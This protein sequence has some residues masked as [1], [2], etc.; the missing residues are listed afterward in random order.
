MGSPSVSE[1]PRG[2]LGR[3]EA[4]P[5]PSSRAW[6]RGLPPSLRL[7]AASPTEL[8]FAGWWPARAPLVLSPVWLALASLTW[9]AP[10]PS[11]GGRVLVSLLCL[12]V[13][14]GLI[15]RGRP[16]RV[17]VR[18]QPNEL[19]LTWAGGTVEAL[20]AA[21]RWLLVVEQAPEAPQPRYAAVLV[22]GE[23]RWPL[24]V[25]EDPARLLR[26]L[27]TVLSHWPGEVAQ[28]WGLPSSVQPWV[29]RPAAP[30]AEPGAPGERLV[31][32]GWRAAAGLRWVLG[33]M[34]GLVLLDLAFLLVTASGHVPAVHPLGLAL[35]ALMASCLITIAAS[36]AT[37]HPRLVV[38]PQLAVEQR[39]LGLRGARQQVPSNAVRGV[40]PLATRGSAQH[41]LIDSSEGPL[42]LLV[43]AREAA[44][45][46][47]E[48][49][50]SLARLAHAVPAS[51]SITSVPRRWQSG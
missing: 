27:R 51:E 3:S 23:Q 25:S 35:P 22:H 18:V 34:T 40:Y 46:R 32:R 45:V 12:G 20:P 7:A 2:P 24:L 8:R 38:G 29:F 1:A 19:Q 48:L 47:E 37:R 28:E 44:Q 30:P 41:L 4:D 13:A 43:R 9:L 16:R 33:V 10:S 17:E 11:D 49:A 5:L 14:L 6:A 36:V 42:A 39:V 21:A 31:L 50:R 15:A 26:E